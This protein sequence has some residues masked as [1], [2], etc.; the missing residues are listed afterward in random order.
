MKVIILMILK[1]YKK[2]VS[3]FL[4]H[5]IYGGCKFSPTCSEYALES[6]S[7]YGVLRGSKLFINRLLRCNP[8]SSGYFDPV[9][10]L[11]ANT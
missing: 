9:S 5:Y 6:I 3:P 1:I 10:D 2:G 4:G 11:K 8:F 7:R